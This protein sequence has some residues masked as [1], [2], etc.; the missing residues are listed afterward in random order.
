MGE[1]HPARYIP[2][3]YMGEVHPAG[4]TLPGYGRRHPAGYTLPGYMGDPTHPGYTTTYT[5]WVYPTHPGTASV[6]RLLVLSP[7]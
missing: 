1:V 4:Y 5:P 2:P 3:G 7:R 6:R